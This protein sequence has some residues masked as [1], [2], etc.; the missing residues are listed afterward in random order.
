MYSSSLVVNEVRTQQ[1]LRQV[2]LW[3]VAGLGITAFVAFI[4]T[5]QS[6]LMNLFFSFE[7]GRQTMSTLGWIVMFAPL[8]A[9]LG[10]GFFMQ[11]ASKA[12]M[13]GMYVFITACFGVTMAPISIIYTPQSILLTLAATMGSFGGFAAWDS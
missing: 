13:I 6:G 8:A 2:G 3:M 10:M 4:L 5:Q 12:A 9:V 1:F 7:N 11:K